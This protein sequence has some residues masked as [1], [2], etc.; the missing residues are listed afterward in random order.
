MKKKKFFNLSVVK[1]KNCLK[2]KRN[3][4]TL[5]EKCDIMSHIEKVMTNKEAV[6][7]FGVPKNITL[8]WVKTKKNIFQALEESTPGTKKLGG[9]NTKRLTRL[10]LNVFFVS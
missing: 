2:L 6:N 4:K 1:T 7:V 9:C 8:T 3:T 5:K 10:S